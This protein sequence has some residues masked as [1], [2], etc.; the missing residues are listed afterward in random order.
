MSGA[1][2][3]AAGIDPV[4]VVAADTRR[5]ADGIA[6]G[7]GAVALLLTAPGTAAHAVGSLEHLGSAAEAFPDRWRSADEDEVQAGDDSLLPFGPQVTHRAELVPDTD[8]TVVGV[9][10]PRVQ[11]AGV[12]GCAALPAALL[13][14][15]GR[16]RPANGA[17]LGRWRQPRLPLRPGSGVRRGRGRQL[18]RCAAGSTRHRRDCR[19]CAASRRTRRPPGRGA[20]G[21]R[22]WRWRGCAAGAAAQCCSPRRR[23]ARTTGPTR[24]WSRTG[25]PGT[26]AC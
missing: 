23:S 11:R 17:E 21:T 3:V 20:T 4:L 18:P 9:T 19:S 7:D 10:A 22:T 8:V 13:L 1:A 15:V 6:Y 24:R 5:D 2:L 16:R 12:L 26:A 25:S 14:G